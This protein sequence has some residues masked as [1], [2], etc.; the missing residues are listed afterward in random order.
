MG[1]VSFYPKSPS[2]IDNCLTEDQREDGATGGVRARGG[3]NLPWEQE[4]KAGQ[5]VYE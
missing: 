4:E 1:G 3:G 5:K 2:G